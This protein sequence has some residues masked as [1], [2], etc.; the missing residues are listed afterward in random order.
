MIKLLCYEPAG[1]RLELSPDDVSRHILAIGAT[2][3]GKTTALVNPALQ[4]LLGWQVSNP[5]A[6]VGL[7]ILDAKVDETPEKTLEWARQAG[8]QSDVL[9]LSES[10]DA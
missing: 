2:G 10:G 6:K 9:V 3:S 5:E 4:Q 8:R 7:L 1:L